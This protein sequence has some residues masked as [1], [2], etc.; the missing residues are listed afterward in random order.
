[1]ARLY[2]S[3][4]LLRSFGRPKRAHTLKSARIVLDNSFS[5]R[6]LA[7]RALRRADLHSIPRIF[8][9][10]SYEAGFFYLGSM[11][12]WF[13][14]RGTRDSIKPPV[15]DID[16]GYVYPHLIHNHPGNRFSDYFPSIGDLEK[17]KG[18]EV[19]TSQKGIS[20][21]YSMRI[22]TARK[23]FTVSAPSF[24]RRYHVDY[25]VWRK[26]YLRF[27]IPDGL[28]SGKVNVRVFGFEDRHTRAIEFLPWEDF[29][30]K[31]GNCSIWDILNRHIS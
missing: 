19:V 7:L 11:D 17:I 10:P 20:L 4:A 21:H 6:M 12:Q 29:E 13:I 18:T 22:R 30:E 31:F 14:V 28:L 25:D 8:S 5:G 16:G 24:A 2:V 9:D 27:R 26:Q 15:L 1:M 3:E 23:G